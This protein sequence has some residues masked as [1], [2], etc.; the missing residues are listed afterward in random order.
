MWGAY[1]SCLITEIS[2]IVQLSL[3]TVN[4]CICLC[5]NVKRGLIFI[6]EST[7]EA[8]WW[9]V[10]LADIL[11][12]AP[13]SCGSAEYRQ[14]SARACLTFT[15]ALSLLQKQMPYFHLAK[16]ILRIHY[17]MILQ[18]NE[19]ISQMKC[20]ADILFGSSFSLH[21]NSPQSHCTHRCVDNVIGLHSTPRDRGET[22]DLSVHTILCHFSHPCDYINCV[23]ACVRIGV[24]KKEWAAACEFSCHITLWFPIQI[25]FFFAL[26]LLLAF[27]RSS[28]LNKLPWGYICEDVYLWRFRGLIEG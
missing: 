18:S 21:L 28:L 4:N 24:C 15:T 27:V 16:C 12:A 17:L 8:L 3:I 20:G 14:N 25:F 22:A 13:A 2:L 23:H 11:A 19:L 9:T 10:T 26:I 5:F 7:S 6:L 1:F